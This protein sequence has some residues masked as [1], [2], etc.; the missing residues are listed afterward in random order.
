MIMKL[1]ETMKWLLSIS[2]ALF[3]VAI[4]KGDDWP[5]WRGAQG[6]GIV[7]EKGLAVKWPDDGPPKLWTKQVGRGHSSPVV[8]EG[9][10]YL[11]S[12]DEDK[13]QEVLAAY[14]ANTGNALWEQR[15]L[16]GYN[17]QSDPSWHGTRATPVVEAGKIYTYGGTGDLICRELSK[18]EPVW[19]T[20]VLKETN[21]KELEWGEA[22][23]PLIVGDV[24]YVQG[25]VGAG[26]PVAVA[27]NK[28]DG[29][30]IWQSDS[31]GE[32]DG[33]NH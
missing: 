4:V 27:V 17:K 20:N 18:G 22:A 3:S 33:V 24:T 10:L 16:G 12:R 31:K 11:F 14:D 6:D 15:N 21:A 28:G 8:V 1:N 25:G 32:A 7:R 29:K 9:K 23:S 13:N 5:Q 26:A 19:H 30:I 2:L